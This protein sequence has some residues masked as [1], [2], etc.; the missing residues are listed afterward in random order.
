MPLG[1][2]YS[3]EE[4]ITGSAEHGGLQIAVYPMKREVFERRFP[5]SLEDESCLSL[6]I[7]EDDLGLAPGGRMRQEI[8][9]DPYERQ[10]WH[11]TK[12]SRCF[13]HL[14]N[15]MVWQSI[16]GSAPPHPTLTAKNYTQ[17]GLPWFDYYDDSQAALAGLA[18]LAKL[19]SV[20]Q[21]SFAKG[22][23]V[24]PENES[25]T[26]TNVIEFRKELKREQVRE[27]QF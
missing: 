22:E 9:E 26:P 16:T 24:L 12:S 27:G 2:G 17:A 10:D 15:S 19:K 20:T 7:E 25:V 14:C 3:A 8:Y 4:Q 13:V 11:D 1:S 5:K 23:V 21:K 18:I 6:C